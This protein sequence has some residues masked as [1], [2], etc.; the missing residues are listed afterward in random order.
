MAEVSSIKVIDINSIKNYTDQ[1]KSVCERRK[2]RVEK[3]MKK[4]LQ[5]LHVVN[6]LYRQFIF[7]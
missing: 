1:K 5:Y 4:K 7:Y 6:L 2:T 3:K